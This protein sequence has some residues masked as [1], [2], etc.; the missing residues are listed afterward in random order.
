M[1]PSPERLW[2]LA[3]DVKMAIIDGFASAGVDLPARQYVSY[4]FPAHDCAQLVVAAEATAG[5]EGALS[6]EVVEPVLG[7][8]GHAMRYA[9]FGITLLRCV[10]V[11]QDDGDPP[12]VEDEEEAAETVLADTV[13]LLNSIVAAQRSGDLNRCGGVA[14]EQWTAISPLGGL[15][16][17]IL[18][19][20][21]LLE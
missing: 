7:K 21:L 9:R 3:V 14:F 8:P 6:Q 11:V 18:R 1:P 20:R 4:G 15:G 19:V 2:N 12:T 10:P 16:G 13:L 5:T 17:G